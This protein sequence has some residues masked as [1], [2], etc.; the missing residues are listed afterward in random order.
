MNEFENILIINE[1]EYQGGF[2]PQIPKYNKHGSA[3]ILTGGVCNDIVIDERTTTKEIRKGKYTKLVEIS[4]R[5][6]M[7]EIR[8]GAASKDKAYSF[9]VYVKATI[10]VT[11][12][13]LFYQNKN[14]DVEG[15]FNNLF[16]MDVRKITKSYS[17]LEYDGMDDELKRML[18]SSNTVDN[19]TGFTY[20]INVVDATPGEKA[21]NY[22][23]QYSKQQLDAEL[24]RRARELKGS[25]ST[26]Y[27]EAIMTEVVEGKKTEA[28]ALIEIENYEEGNFEKIINRLEVLRERGLITD[29][30]AKRYVMPTLNYTGINQA[31]NSS[32]QEESISGK[33]NQFYDEED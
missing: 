2:F 24:K 29:R 32:N 21:R 10:Q 22:V 11:D 25:Y 8:F 33:F 14:I 28:E 30:D 5:P 18:S 16:S 7:R 15:Y 31:D 20:R 27:K 26:D 3:Y 17:I 23:E 19:A 9:D 4:T 12:P 13:I 1:E 6:Y